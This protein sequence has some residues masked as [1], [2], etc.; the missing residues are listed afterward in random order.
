MKTEVPVFDAVP[1]A[2]SAIQRGEFVLV[3]DDTERE[4]EGDLIIAAEKIS[5]Q[6]NGVYGQA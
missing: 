4:N 5:G 3:V 1:A 6:S 2:I